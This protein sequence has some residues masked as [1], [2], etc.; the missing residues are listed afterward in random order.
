MEPLTLEDLHGNGW[1]HAA[2]GAG[3]SAVRRD[4]SNVGL[5]FDLLYLQ[6]G[7]PSHWVRGTVLPIGD[8]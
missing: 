7:S 2:N 8:A 6:R 1:I 4:E 3:G 5:S